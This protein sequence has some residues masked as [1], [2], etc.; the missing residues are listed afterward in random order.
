MTDQRRIGSLAAVPVIRSAAG[1]A[2]LV[3]ATGALVGCSPSAP[4]FDPSI[5]LNDGVFKGESGP[6]EQG[7]FGRATI[8]VT[9]GHITASEFVVVQANGSVKAEDYGKDSQ[10]QIANQQAYQAAQK[11]VAAFDVYAR[12]LMETGVPADVDVVSG[13]TIAHRQ[14]LE[15]ATEALV[16]SQEAG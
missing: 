3:G 9:N 8:T 1:L 4:P 16:Q 12:D 7:A 10:G 13:A 11:A 14:F 2:A 6:D 15:A 5:P